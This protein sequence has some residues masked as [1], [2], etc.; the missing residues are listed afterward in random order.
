MK[1]YEYYMNK[2]LS[3]AIK[4]YKNDEVPVGAIMVYQGKIIASAYNQKDSMNNVLKH[5]ELI[6]IEKASKKLKNWR[7]NGCTLFVTLEPC[8]MCASALQQAR[9]D[10]VVYGTPSTNNKNHYLVDKIFSEVDINQSISYVGGIL[11]EKCG[12][13]LSDFFEK[14]RL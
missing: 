1:D 12:N 11:Q 9:V 2:A 3:C 4:G 7:L 5:A 13:L 10:K 14:K 6:C 8:P